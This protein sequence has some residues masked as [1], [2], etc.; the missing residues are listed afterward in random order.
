MDN[1]MQLALTR[2]VV[3]K[4]EKEI[5]DLKAT[6]VDKDKQISELEIEVSN[7]EDDCFHD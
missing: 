5:T 6:I 2:E 7:W 3:Q 4:Q 1:A